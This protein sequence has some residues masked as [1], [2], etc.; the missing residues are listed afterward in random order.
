MQKKRRGVTRFCP[1]CYRQKFEFSAITPCYD[2][3]RAASE[4]AGL[5]KLCRKCIDDV[6]A[7]PPVHVVWHKDYRLPPGYVVWREG[8]RP[9][10]GHV[11][12]RKNYRP[13]PG[14]VVWR[15]DYR[16]PYRAGTLVETTSETSTTADGEE[17]TKDFCSIKIT[18]VCSD[19]PHFC[20][21]HA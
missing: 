15:K 3:G 7:P 14:F 1:G 13:A 8:Y 11:A 4:E 6:G 10:P 17:E 21:L 9:P 19:L 18:Y 16:Q 12:W 20:C 5:Q 2:C